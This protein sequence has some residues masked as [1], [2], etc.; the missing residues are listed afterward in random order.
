MVCFHAGMDGL[1]VRLHHTDVAAEHH[2][3]GCLPQ[4]VVVVPLDALADFEGRKDAV[5]LEGTGPSSVLAR[6]EDAGVPQVKE[7]DADDP[8]QL[9]QFPDPPKVMADIDADF[10]KALENASQ[11]AARESS[12]Y[13]VHHIQLR[14]A[15]GQ[16]IATD[17]KQM[18]VQS[19]FRLPFT[20][21]VLIPS[22]TAF[23][24][25]ELACEAGVR[26]GK[27]DTHVCLSIGAWTFHLPIDK[28]G[29]FPNA[30]QVIPSLS[31]SVTRWH[32]DPADAAFLA[33]ALPK[34]PGG[35]DDNGPVT[36]DLNGQAM[37]RARA[38]GQPNSTE[39]VLV[40]SEVAGPAVRFGLNR[41]FLARALHLGFADV[42]VVKADVPL[43]FKDDNRQLIVMPLGKDGTLPPSADCLRIT[44]GDNSANGTSIP[45]ERRTPV[46]TPSLN[47]N[48]K[49]PTTSPHP[50]ANGDQSFAGGVGIAA[51]IAEAEAL[52]EVMHAATGRASRLVIALRR[53][54]KQSRLVQTTLAS[55]KQLHQ[56]D[57]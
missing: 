3:P 12:R 33:K 43:V 35:A 36:V 7:Y 10:F 13:A 49:V 2:Q 44:S 34:L 5:T 46:S 38:D 19:G 56:I 45:T 11:S 14:G 30:D 24:C 21:E 31:G 27:S 23:G 57:A 8:A 51:L 55:L 50:I 40:R 29:R 52:K 53:H 17:G 48:D 47:G 16:V 28:E 15:A 32:L 41:Q 37:V 6:W 4:E 54:R 1:R 39:L 20:D 25:R 22:T 18:L 26:I 9:A 42:T